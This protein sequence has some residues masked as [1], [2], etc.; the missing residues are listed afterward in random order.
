VKAV[1][2]H[3]EQCSEPAQHD[4]RQLA[5]IGPLFG[6]HGIHPP[7]DPIEAGRCRAGNLLQYRQSRSAGPARFRPTRPRSRPSPRRRHHSNSVRARPSR[8]RSRGGRQPSRITPGDAVSCTDAMR[9]RC[10]YRCASP[11]WHSLRII[12]GRCYRRSTC[13]ADLRETSAVIQERL[14][15]GEQELGHQVTVATAETHAPV[16]MGILNQYGPAKIEER[17]TQGHRRWRLSRSERVRASV[18]AA[19]IALGSDCDVGGTHR[20][21]NDREPELMCSRNGHRV[22]PQ[23]VDKRPA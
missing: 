10:D 3:A 21:S 16:V 22:V 23:R 8:T 17:V 6:G 1:R 18:A 5:E 19:V 12:A 15:Q 11:G 20:E 4:A 7:L 14:P 2:H 9:R 13:L